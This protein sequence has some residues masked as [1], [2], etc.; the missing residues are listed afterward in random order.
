MSFNDDK[1]PDVT[2]GELRVFLRLDDR[3]IER[4]RI[5]G[6]RCTVDAGGAKILVLE[7]VDPKESVD[8]LAGL[9]VRYEDLADEALAALAF[10]AE[11]SAGRTLLKFTQAGSPD[12]QRAKAAFWLGSSRG[13]ES[14]P[15]L[16]EMARKDPSAHVREQAIFAISISNAPGSEALLVELARRDPRPE[17]RSKALFWLS[18]E[19]SERIAADA[20]REAVEADPNVEVK[21]QA[22]FALS[23]LPPE[24]GVPL[25][26]DI[27]RGENRHP[28]VRRAAVFWLGQSG[29]PRA[30]EFFEEVLK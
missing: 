29:D 28:S 10:H 30:L 24:R 22:V 1:R 2:D 6:G 15:R 14:L 7:G 18:Q 5:F 12:W 26:I 25:L 8:L 4:V 9:V 19:A 21:E 23:Q 16:Q 11:A 17:T 20:I 13:E 27:A 3:R